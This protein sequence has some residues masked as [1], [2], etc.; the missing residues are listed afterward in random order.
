M[1]TMIDRLRGMHT[2]HSR[3]IPLY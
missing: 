2:T 1:A 3:I